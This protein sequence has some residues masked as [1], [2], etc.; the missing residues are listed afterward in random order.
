MN[1]HHDAQNAKPA[2]SIEHSG[3]H[4][5]MANDGNLFLR[6]FWYTTVLL[7][8]LLI[9]SNVGVKFLA[10]P[11]FDERQY[12]GFAISAVIFY[13]SLIFFA[14]AGHEFKS[15]QFGMMTL[16]SVAVAS[17]FLF[18]VASTFFPAF[19]GTE[20]FLEISTLIWVLLFG[21]YLEARSTT[22]AGAALRE[23][24]KLL[25][26][27]AHILDGAETR[28]LPI[29]EL[30]PGDIVVLKPGEKAPADGQIIE[31]S[32]NM[33][34]AL[35]TGESKPISKKVG[36]LVI[37]GSICLDGRL[38]VRVERVGL[39]S[40]VGRIKKL[41]ESAQATKPRLQ[42][43]ADRV[44]SLLT[45]V[46][47]GTAVLTVLVWTLVVGQPFAFALT[48]AVTVLVI[49]CPHALGLAIPTVSTTATSLALKHGIFLKSLK[50]LEAARNIT[51]VAFDKTGTLTEGRPAVTD[52]VA[53]GM[54]TET[55]LVSWAA[56]LEQ[57]S[58][59]PIAKAILDYAKDKNISFKKV[60]NFKYL[61]GRGGTGEISHI[62]F[63]IGNEHV[64][65]GLSLGQLRAS[66][67]RLSDE[68]K[69]VTILRSKERIHGLVA[70]AD[71]VRPESKEAVESLH[72]MGVKVAMI[73]GD[74]QGVAKYVAAEL[75]IDSFFA[76][77]LPEDKYKK[78]KELQAMGETVMMVGD[79]VNDAPA[80]IQANVGVAIGVGTDLTIEA[81][82]I[83]LTENN[84]ADVARL[85]TLAKK[86]YRKMIQNLVWA[87]GY[88]IV[89]I[90]AAA[91][92]FAK[93]GIF[94]RPD[95][96]AFLMAISSVI[97]VVN[98]LQL[99]RI[100]L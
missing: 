68:G 84:P 5:T 8:P 6:R 88:N 99:K 29:D 69:T 12:I 62:Q 100:K 73:T 34:E 16:V 95:V 30:K 58:S 65:D 79:G 54:T 13:F 86:V 64:L 83:I 32:A 97:V 75:G 18:S 81:G 96:G 35:I 44:A 98:A 28:D 63:R 25:P 93:L 92:V 80:L 4:P 9:V 1:H 60:R 52:V 77:V 36:D 94:L 22:A 3:H 85:L 70:V 49:A 43:L 33:D 14:H 47:L 20:F 89:A 23:V 39:E 53:S 11:D 41:I 82:D 38:S 27:E 74:N 42:H 78:I 40:T 59:H 26:K 61:S 7:A 72:R 57:G 45:F 71:R 2:N 37:A 17:G 66:F 10:V 50:K 19:G 31:G 24:A 87:V 46:A 90:P 67:Q 51:Y 76:S 91:G 15:R 21:H 48:L 56:S 55:E